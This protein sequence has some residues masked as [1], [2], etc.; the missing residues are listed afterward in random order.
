[1]LMGK[2]G[3][4]YLDTRVDLRVMDANMAERNNS[5]TERSL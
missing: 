3:R 2:M 4:T 5:R 1:M